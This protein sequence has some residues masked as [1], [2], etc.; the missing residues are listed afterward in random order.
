MVGKSHRNHNRSHH[1]HLHHEDDGR[2]GVPA[3]ISEADR[4]RQQIQDRIN[5]ID[6][7]YK[8]KIK[9][10]QDW[11]QHLPI[12]DFHALWDKTITM[13]EFK[14][15]ADEVTAVETSQYDLEIKREHEAVLKIG[16]WWRARRM[17][18]AAR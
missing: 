11:S 1:N 17:R 5:L 3:A 18:E 6:D 7:E 8:S 2:F 14:Q 16:A 15:A 10:L 9:E 12:I 13:A 4:I